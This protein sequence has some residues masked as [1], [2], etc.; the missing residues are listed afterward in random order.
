MTIHQIP[1]Y[2][3]ID[4]LHKGATVKILQ[5]ASFVDVTID[6]LPDL[7]TE[8]QQT[9]NFLRPSTEPPERPDPA[10]GQLFNPDEYSPT[11]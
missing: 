11:P 4:V 2:Q 7:I 3:P 6:S 5:G 9:H 1:G 8:L 10:Q